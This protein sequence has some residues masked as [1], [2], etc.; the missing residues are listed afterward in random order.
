MHRPRTIEPLRSANAEGMDVRVHVGPM[1]AWEPGMA[2]RTA[3]F[4]MARGT[5]R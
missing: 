5:K 3:S 1:I 4:P 2:R